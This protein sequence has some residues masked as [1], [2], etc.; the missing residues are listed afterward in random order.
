MMERTWK[1]NESSRERLGQER[2]TEKQDGERWTL[3]W[4]Y[5]WHHLMDYN[6]LFIGDG[7]R[8]GWI[9]EKRGYKR[10][11]NTWRSGN[12][13]CKTHEIEKREGVEGIVGVAKP[14]WGERGQF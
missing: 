10:R 3:S 4:S 1:K 11:E 5:A 7:A 2:K 8:G 13:V 12:V 14:K 6:G 9:E